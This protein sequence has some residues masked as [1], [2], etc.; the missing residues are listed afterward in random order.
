MVYGIIAAVFLLFLAVSAAG[1]YYMYRYAVVRR[2]NAADCWAHP[3]QLEPPQHLSPEKAAL[4]Q[5]D[6]EY[7]L[8]HAGKP[9]YRVSRDG[10]T[11]AC[12]MLH[13]TDAHT[14][15]GIFLCCHGYRSHAVYDFAG[16]A[17]YLLAMGFSLCLIDERAC[18]SSGG[19]YITFGLREKD[20]VVDWACWLQ[21]RF[22]DLPV[23]LY[24]VS[25]GASSVLAASGEPLPPSVRGIVADCGYTSA[26]A[27]C[28]RVLR[29]TFHLPPFPVYYAALVLIWLR[30]GVWFP[31]L[32]CTRAVTENRLPLLIVHGRA[33]DFVPFSMGE[34]IYDAAKA[35]CDAEFFAAADAS[36]ARSWLCDEDGYR[37][38][39][40]RLLHKAG[41]D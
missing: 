11:L 18:G 40:K 33:D 35:H 25:M 10:V 7:V 20:D 39:I 38:A 17:Q 34:A 19:R 28:K 22:P 37:A 4:V 8:T 2:K 30:T 14:S 32:D 9:Y 13:P 15:R 29:Q 26:C 16:A 31:D 23:L 12:R 6:R 5:R 24:G 27:I 1:G 21:E 36:H 3:E 41:I